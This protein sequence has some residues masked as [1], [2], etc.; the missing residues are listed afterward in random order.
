MSQ[1]IEKISLTGYSGAK[2]QLISLRIL[3]NAWLGNFTQSEPP[4]NRVNTFLRKSNWLIKDKTIFCYNEHFHLFFENICRY[5]PV[6]MA[7]Y[8]IVKYREITDYD[9]KKLWQVL[10]WDVK[11]YFIIEQCTLRLNLLLRSSYAS[12]IIKR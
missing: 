2:F 3:E 8:D 9:L 6:K 10:Q 5:Y 12:V 1:W 7:L 11:W 4:W